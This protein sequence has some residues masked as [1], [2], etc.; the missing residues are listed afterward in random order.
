[1]TR[2]RLV[3]SLSPKNQIGSSNKIV[4]DFPLSWT[5]DLESNRTI[6]T[7]PVCSAITNTANTITCS[8]TTMPSPVNRA[9]ITVTG[10][11]STSISSAFSF[12]IQSILT[13]PIVD[14]SD[15]VVISSQQSDG[16]KIDTCT[17]VVTN[18]SPIQFQ[19]AIFESTSNTMVQ[20]SFNGRVSL[21][22]AKPFA[23]YDTVVFTLPSNFLN[24][25]VSSTSFSS[26]SQ[27]RDA[28]SSSITLANFPSTSS[29]STSSQLIFTLQS[30]SNPV[31]TNPVN[32]V[33]SFYRLG[34]LYQQSTLSYSAVAGTAQSFKILP[35]SNFV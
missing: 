34:S 32:V 31:S 35:S 3:V 2:S 29:R 25:V 20:T 26:F 19:T 30:I 24:G 8:Y 18:L 12:S 1:M 15:T 17:T 10:L 16:S 14:S 7:N 22:I 4:L 21:S 11:T 28:S 6:I 5:N 13:P 23:Y 33:V 27:T 9:Y